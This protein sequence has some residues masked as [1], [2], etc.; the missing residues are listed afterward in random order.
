MKFEIL[1]R[2]KNISGDTIKQ[3]INCIKK[4]KTNSNNCIKAWRNFYKLVLN[5]EPPDFLKTKKT[6]PDLKVPTLDE[7]V[8]TLAAAKQYPIIYN[9]YRLL[10]E[11]G[12]REIEVLGALNNYDPAN[13]KKEGDFY[14]YVLNWQ[15]GQKKI[16]YLF[17]ISPIQK[18]NLSKSQIDKAV[19]KLKLVPPKYIRKFV[20]TRMAEL[21][22]PSEIIDFIQGR[23]PS[24]I[25]SKHYLNLFALSK[26]NYKKYAE[27]LKNV[28]Q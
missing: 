1:L 26:E 23:T 7:I 10:L 9:V 24:S 3:Y 28:L 16:F 17:H 25:L 13:D 8:R 5:Q 21:G 15:R 2:Q 14:I 4:K 6:K 18:L 12:A 19:K 27:W 22:I 11:S 20:A